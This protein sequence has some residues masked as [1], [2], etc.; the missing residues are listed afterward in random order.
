[1]LKL[2]KAAFPECDVYKEGSTLFIYPKINLEDDD[3][4]IVLYN[5]DGD[6]EVGYGGCSCCGT[7]YHTP[8]ID[9][10]IDQLERIVVGEDNESIVHRAYKIQELMIDIAGKRNALVLK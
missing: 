8:E 6:W 9:D 5:I 1:M 10:L 7:Q 2:M 3:E 4:A